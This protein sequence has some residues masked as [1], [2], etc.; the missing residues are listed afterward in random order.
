[1]APYGTVVVALV[2]FTVGNQAVIIYMVKGCG[3]YIG[4]IVE[5]SV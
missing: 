2:E 5:I 1:M 4:M 3:I